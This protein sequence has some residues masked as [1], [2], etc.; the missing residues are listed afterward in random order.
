MTI[1]FAS[2]KL[3]Q[4]FEQVF[5]SNDTSLTAESCV[6][7]AQ[8]R[9][10]VTTLTTQELGRAIFQRHCYHT[11]PDSGGD[12]GD[13][14]LISQADLKG[15]LSRAQKAG[16]QSLTFKVNK[17]ILKLHIDHAVVEGKVT[18][19]ARLLLT[20]Y[21]G[22]M[23]DFEPPFP[24]QSK[25]TEIAAED[26]NTWVSLLNQ[27]GEFNEKAGTVSSSAARTLLINIGATL[28]GWTNHKGMMCYLLVQA[29]ISQPQVEPIAVSFEG[30]HLRRLIGLSETEPVQVYLDTH[31]NQ[32]WI[33]FVGDQGRMSF[34]TAAE[35]SPRLQLDYKLLS[36]S[37][38]KHHAT[39]VA[40]LNEISSS[41]ELQ[42]PD[43]TSLVQDLV[44]LEQKPHLVIMQAANVEGSELSYVPVNPGDETTGNW[45]DIKVHLAIAAMVKSLAMFFRQ[46]KVVSGAIALEQHTLKKP[47]GSSTAW[48]LKLL[49]CVSSTVALTT[50][51]IAVPLEES[52]DQIDTAE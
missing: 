23:S 46:T 15:K 45:Q 37:R 13:I 12:V 26:F 51:I 9:S 1:R 42:R 21:G 18:E 11:D 7:V 27:F 29:E 28:Q 19:R 32:Q 4:T 43:E 44:I 25:V 14:Y 41:V 36:S 5:V 10:N 24:V 16:A 22:S 8:T 35:P 39:R 33:T 49:P 20:V 50:F 3:K 17:G 38:L 40:T 2:L 31:N 30:R 34:T 47:K 52:L 48:V 6:H